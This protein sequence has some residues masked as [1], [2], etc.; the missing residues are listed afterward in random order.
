MLLLLTT[1]PRGRSCQWPQAVLIRACRFF[2]EHKVKGT[3]RG[4]KTNSAQPFLPKST[5]IHEEK[6]QN[7]NCFLFEVLW[8]W[9][10][11]QENHRGC[12]RRS[13]FTQGMRENHL[14]AKT[15]K[16]SLSRPT[17]APAPAACRQRQAP[18]ARPVPCL[19][20]SEQAAGCLET[21]WTR[22]S[23]FGRALCWRLWA[24]YITTAEVPS[25]ESR[26]FNTIFMMIVL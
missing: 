8:T 5:K 2:P 22:T 12:S 11:T 16:A 1:V 18:A 9:I 13:R 26:D 3:L 4:D 6:M 10:P 20:G 15:G 23:P 7:S 19:R 17:P 14:K 24:S 25:L 21:A